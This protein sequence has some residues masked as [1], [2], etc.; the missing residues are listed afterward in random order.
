MLHNW[1]LSLQE[2]AHAKSEQ[3]AEVFYLMAAQKYQEALEINKN[4]HYALFL[5]GR[6][7]IKFE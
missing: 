4:D 1:G 6:T 3:E 5:W 7:V 2:R